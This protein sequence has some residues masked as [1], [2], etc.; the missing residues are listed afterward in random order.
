MAKSSITK[1]KSPQTLPDVDPSSLYAY[2]ID[3]AALQ[4]SIDSSLKHTPDFFTIVSDPRESFMD[5]TQAPAGFACRFLQE[6]RRLA[7]KY[8][9]TGNR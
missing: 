4:R 5:E 8:F 9:S 3:P 7:N 6:A 1:D 2:G